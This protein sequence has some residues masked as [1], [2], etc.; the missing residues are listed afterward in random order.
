MPVS[1]SYVSALIGVACCAVFCLSGCQQTTPTPAPTKTDQ[2]TKTDLLT[3][4]DWFLTGRVSQEQATS[5]GVVTAP[6]DVFAVMPN[7]LKDDMLSFKTNKTFTYSANTIHC[8]FDEVPRQG[9]WTFANGEERLQLGVT[10]AP[11]QWMDNVFGGP[12]YGEVQII[13]LSENVLKLRS[14]VQ[15]PPATMSPHVTTYTYSSTGT[16][17]NTDAQQKAFKALTAHKWR[18]SSCT[19][20]NTMQSAPVTTD[21]LAQMPACRRD[22]FLQF[23][24]DY[25]LVN[26]E[27]ATRCNAADPQSRATSWL[28]SDNG[29]FSL[30]ARA[31]LGLPTLPV[32]GSITTQVTDTKL[33]ISFYDSYHVGQY[34]ATVIEYT[35]F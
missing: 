31:I 35:A 32:N 20:T 24:A 11:A 26:D 6:W 12:V 16:V 29:S 30:K 18:M 7:C 8:D 10:T 21:I 34:D 22:D 2:I 19:N 13:E 25:T 17:L 23:N 28:Q 33:T 5:A 15:T 27:G 3:A 9:S 4:H 14:S 1:T